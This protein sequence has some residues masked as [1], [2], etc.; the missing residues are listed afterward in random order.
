MNDLGGSKDKINPIYM[1]IIYRVFYLHVI[2]LLIFSF[3]CFCLF[4]VLFW[5]CS[6]VWGELIVSY[7]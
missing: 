4:F 3:V 5:F 7:K 1:S 6:T 2:E